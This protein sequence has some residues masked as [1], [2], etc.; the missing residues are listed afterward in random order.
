MWQD[1]SHR[2]AETHEVKANGYRL[3]KKEDNA[4]GSSELDAERA[5]D[6]PGLLDDPEALDLTDTIR[7]F[8]DLIARA[9]RQRESELKERACNQFL[10]ISR[11]AGSRG[12]E[13]ALTRR[14]SRARCSRSSASSWWP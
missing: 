10:T 8:R 1:G 6:V 4:D 14:I 7:R 11:E 13:V 9:A 3:G 2:L 5:Q 12:A